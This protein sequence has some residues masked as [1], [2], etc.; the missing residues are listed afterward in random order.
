MDP[1]LL[2]CDALVGKARFSIDG[3]VPKHKT[4][5]KAV[6]WSHAVVFTGFSLR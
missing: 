1:W 3:F 6:G 2:F 4:G 5:L